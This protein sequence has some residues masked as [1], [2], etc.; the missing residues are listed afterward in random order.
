MMRINSNH[1]QKETKMT[2][3][4]TQLAKE[5][6]MQDEMQNRYPLLRLSQNGVDECFFVGNSVCLYDAQHNKYIYAVQSAGDLRG[7]FD[8]VKSR[9]GELVSLITDAQ[10]GETARGFEEGML[11]NYC[12]QF[13]LAPYTNTPPAVPGVSF[14][15]VDRQIA[16]WILSVYEHPELS[17]NFILR[18]A[19]SA[20]AVAAIYKGNPVGFFITHS[21]AELGPIYVD[22]AFRSKGLADALYAEAISQ[23]PKDKPMP[24]LFVFP[25]NH[26]SQKW[27]RRMGCVPASKEVAWFW[28]GNPRKL[29]GC[30]LCVPVQWVF[31]GRSRFRDSAPQ[32]LSPQKTPSIFPMVSRRSPQR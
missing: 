11:V 4:E 13:A 9:K 1:Q 26:A 31:W 15:A 29:K 17:V 23:L 5:L 21:D 24:V 22:P 7:L 25:Q 3:C 12:T 19:A 20:P 28:R 30:L 8:I 6:L 14:S 16:K 27:V 2:E 10:W 32:C 18:R